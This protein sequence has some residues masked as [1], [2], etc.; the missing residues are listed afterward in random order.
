[1]KRTY[2]KRCRELELRP[3]PDEDSLLSHRLD[4]ASDDLSCLELIQSLHLWVFDSL[5]LL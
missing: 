1:M 4:K 5:G 2:R 3:L